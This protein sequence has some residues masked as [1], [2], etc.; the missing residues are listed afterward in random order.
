M[1]ARNSLRVFAVVLL[2]CGTAG[3]S[4]AQVGSV[5]KWPFEQ[6]GAGINRALLFAEDRRSRSSPRPE[7]ARTT[8]GL[9]GPHAGWTTA[10]KFG[11]L[12]LQHSLRWDRYDLFAGRDNRRFPTTQ[13]TFTPAEVSGGFTNSQFLTNQ[14]VAELDYRDDPKDPKAGTMVTGALE[15]RN[16]IRQTAANFTTLRLAHYFYLPLSERKAHIFAFRSEAVHN[17]SDDAIPFYLEPTLGGSNSLRGFR[18]YR[19]RDNDAL[20]ATAEYRYR[21]WTYMDAVI[22][23][24]AGQVY[25]DVFKDAAHTKMEADYG[26]GRAAP[27]LC[28][29]ALRAT[30]HD[31]TAAYRRSAWFPSRPE[32]TACHQVRTSWA[33]NRSR[34]RSDNSTTAGRFWHRARIRCRPCHRQKPDPT[35]STAYP[36]AKHV[37]F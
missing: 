22:F 23:G 5:V 11:P 3:S 26:G 37:R 36:Q 7:S 35:R 19:F 30:I 29:D 9:S 16:G 34:S 1:S 6:V 21:I 24:D 20:I 14:L 2:L 31:A 27:R 28:S 18:E 13:E 12:G 32:G 15:F 4:E 33:R 8:Y 17:L 25:P 10:A